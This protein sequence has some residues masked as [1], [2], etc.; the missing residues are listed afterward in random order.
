MIPI[1]GAFFMPINHITPAKLFLSIILAAFMKRLTRAYTEL[2]FAV[3]LF[4]FAAIFGDLIKV[5]ALS[6]VWWRLLLSVLLFSLVRSIYPE[7]RK[8]TK[9]HI[10]IFLGIGV[11][12]SIHWVCFY[13]SIKL[14]N[15]SV[16][17]ICFSATPLFTALIEPIFMKTPWR[18]VDFIFGILIIPA[19]FFI[20]SSLDFSMYQGVMVGIIS[21]FLA[22]VFN[23][24]NKKYIDVTGP[25]TI[26]VVEMMGALLFLSVIIPIVYSIRHSGGFLPIGND[27]IYL[28]ALVTFCTMLA[29][30]LQLR[31]LRHVSAFTSNFIVSLEPVYGILLAIFILKEHRELNTQFY[32]GVIILVFLQLVYPLLKKSGKM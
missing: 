16:G 29:F 32:I 1:L 15:A 11:I 31:S 28:I 20:L 3:F 9:Q 2:H 17:L 4:G 30:V 27:W 8:L 22:A 21:S 26:F 23:T 25:V 10:Y 14:A 7:L 12:I 5:S 19:M 24:L 18:K 13:G 6:L